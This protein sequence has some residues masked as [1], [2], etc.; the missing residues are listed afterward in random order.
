MILRLGDEDS[1]VWAELNKQREA[2]R[3]A[4]ELTGDAKTEEEY[5]G[6]G[7]EMEQIPEARENALST[8]LLELE[9]AELILLRKDKE[10]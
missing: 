3:L 8:R 2:L 9:R 5:E 6:K 7:E 4:G 10:L 1:D